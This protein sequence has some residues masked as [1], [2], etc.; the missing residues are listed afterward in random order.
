M[1]C[2]YCGK[3]IIVSQNFIT[4][5]DF[6]ECSNCKNFFKF[7]PNNLTDKSTVDIDALKKKSIVFLIYRSIAAIIPIILYYFLTK[8]ESD[9][10]FITINILPVIIAFVIHYLKFD[11]LI[12]YS[13]LFNDRLLNTYKFWLI[14]S[15]LSTTFILNLIFFIII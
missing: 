1:E 4:E 12:N 8:A 9:I 5:N 6:V 10:I 7:I 3:K 15:E 14:F 2:G 13:D 11:E